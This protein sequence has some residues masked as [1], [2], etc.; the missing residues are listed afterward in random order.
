MSGLQ[1]PSVTLPNPLVSHPVPT[2]PRRRPV[3]RH[4]LMAV[5]YPGPI[6]AQPDV[7]RRRRHADDFLPRRRRSH[8]H[9]AIRIMALIRN[10]HTR[11]L[12]QGKGETQ[13]QAVIQKWHVGN[14]MIGCCPRSCRNERTRRRMV[15]AGGG[16]TRTSFGGGYPSFGEISS[17]GSV[18][19]HC[20]WPQSRRM[21]S[22]SRRS[23][24]AVVIMPAVVS[25][26]RRDA[27]RGTTRHGA[28]SPESPHRPWRDTWIHRRGS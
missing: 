9:H 28:P 13:T 7:T 2:G 12:E 25:S 3:P 23:R 20:A 27:A 19:V 1:P 17:P 4:P 5:T 26:H 21:C 8:H 14:R 10:D 11:R 16:K 6:P 24:R 22:Q 15:D 18:S